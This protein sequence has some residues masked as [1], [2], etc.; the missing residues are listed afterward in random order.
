MSSL[1]TPTL[2][3]LKNVS[4]TFLP[5]LQRTTKLIASENRPKLAP[6]GRFFHRRLQLPPTSIG[7]Q[8]KR[9]AFLVL[10]SG[11]T[12]QG[13]VTYADALQRVLLNRLFFFSNGGIWTRSQQGND[14]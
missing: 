4:A 9:R 6:K 5:F 3:F 2:R 11:A 14:P 12:F 1:D 7:F 13:T 8:C 10:W